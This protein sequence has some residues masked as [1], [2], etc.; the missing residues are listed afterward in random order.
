MMMHGVLA[1]QD[2]SGLP[3][4]GGGGKGEGG[5]QERLAVQM[6]WPC[7]GGQNLCGI[8]RS[9]YRFIEE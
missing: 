3:E 5:A 1:Q 8:A 6:G 2:L 7:Q 9:V 4:A